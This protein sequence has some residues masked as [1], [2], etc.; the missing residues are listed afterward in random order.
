MNRERAALNSFL[1]SIQDKGYQ[2]E[3]DKVIARENVYR[4]NE[5]VHL[6]V[7]TSRF[8]QS[9]RIY[10][11]G[12][13]RH[14]FENF[15]QL[16]NAF[17]AFVFGDTLDALIVPAQWMWEQREKLASNAQQYKVEIE[18]SLHM[19][20]FKGAEEP[21]SLALYHERF[22]LL[23]TSSALIPLKPE[24][25]KLSNK[26]AHLQGLLLEIG[27]MRGYQTYSPNK[28]PRFNGKPLGEIATAKEFP[29]FPG[30]GNNIVRQIDVIWLDKLFPI[31]A[32]E[33]ELTTGIWTGLVRLA[34]LKRLNT[35]L[36]VITDIDDRAFRRR[37]SGDIFSDILARCHHANASEIEELYETE[38]KL[39]SIAKNLYL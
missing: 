31:H 16:P 14:I 34:E 13:T 11:F 39:R 23:G 37:V 30:L 19:R 20:V 28:S 4:V 18:K 10:F 22:E 2:I 3:P 1:K 24:P 7:R 32:F 38:V 29:E 15:A 9:R 26:H 8:H 12:L 27:N 25:K 17:I 6:L 33:V 21:I 35:Q 36:H 5:S